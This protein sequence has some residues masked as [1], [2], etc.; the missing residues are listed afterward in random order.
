MKKVTILTIM[1]L[2]CAVLSLSCSNN[3]DTTPPTIN[4]IQPSEGAIL[5]IGADIHLDMVLEDNEML[6]SYKI[7]I[8]NNFNNHEHGTKA[9][10]ETVPFS[11]NNTWDVSSNKNKTVHHH[12]IIIP[13]NATEGDY[14]FMVYCTD[15][16]G[17]ESYVARKIVLSHEGTTILHY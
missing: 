2:T 17:N 13:A 8:H 12:E 11:Y 5:Q 1:L 9:I 6:S 7:E 3:S 16:K 10:A 15:A 14:H 4:L